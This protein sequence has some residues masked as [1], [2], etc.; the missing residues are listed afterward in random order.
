MPVDARKYRHRVEIQRPVTAQNAL[1]ESESTWAVADRRWCRIKPLTGQEA[2][3]A[4]RIAADVTHE[5]RMR[6]DRFTRT[7]TPA[8]RIVF[9][10]RVFEVLIVINDD[11]R[12]LEMIVN[13][14]E[15]I[16]G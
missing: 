15:H 14:R 12:N 2:F 11:E 16:N 3:T 6:S 4:R 8:M 7:M 5:I 10:T 13:C 9:G 1:G